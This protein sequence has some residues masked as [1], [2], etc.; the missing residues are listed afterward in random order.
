MA[1]LA[2]IA[3][4]SL[5]AVACSGDDDDDDDDGGTGT[6]ATTSSG[7][8]T[9]T[10]TTGGGDAQ[11]KLESIKGDDT[12]VTDTEV[13]I[14]TYFAKT[15]PAAVYYPIVEAWTAYF[16]DVNKNGGIAGRKIV[17][18]VQDDGYNPTNTKNVVKKLIEQDG[19]F[20]LFNG[21]GTPPGNA[22]LEDVKSAGVPSYFLATGDAKWADQGDGIIGL[23]PDYVTEGTVLGKYAAQNFKGK[24][25]GIIYQND[26]FGK[27]GLE[28]IKAGI[29][30]DIQIVG[31]ESYEANAPDWNAQATKLLNDGAE[32]IFVYSTPTQFA[33]AL[34]DAKAKG[35]HPIWMSSSVAASSSTAKNAEGGMDGVY[36]AGYIRD[37]TDP[38]PAIQKW[39]KW[40]QDHGLDPGNSFTY[41]GIV[42]AQH[43][44]QLLKVTGKNLNR[45]SIRYALENLAFTGEFQSDLLLRPTKVSA[46]DHKPIEYMWVQQWDEANQKFKYD[47]EKDLID[48]ETSK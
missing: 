28:G 5:L 19:V 12:G 45:E 29:G 42:A 31:E 23:Q 41:Y 15:G 34:K 7:G 17:F 8:S 38:D 48:V 27:E 22:V 30:S 47:V 4:F 46:T 32:I 44:E 13:K 1:L 24:K 6:T 37:P 33:A 11:S 10:A 2:V 26:D 20:M 3:I 9:A 21:L 25:A 16:D 14:G 35:K 39:H 36:T 43:L 40:A 18:D